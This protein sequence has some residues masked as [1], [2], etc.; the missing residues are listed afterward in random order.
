M[1]PVVT[2]TSTDIDEYCRLLFEYITVKYVHLFKHFGKKESEANN[3]KLPAI[4]PDEKDTK[5]S[6]EIKQ[7]SM[8]EFLDTLTYTDKVAEIPVFL[9]K[10]YNYILVKARKNDPAYTLP[11]NEYKLPSNLLYLEML[12]KTIRKTKSCDA[13]DLIARIIT[14]KNYILF[15]KTPP[16]YLC[17]EENS[18]GMRQKIEEIHPLCKEMYEFVLKL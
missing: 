10:C 13:L 5:Q 18:V 14:H 11:D 4:L 3:F 12:F 7:K 9:Q 15:T 8:E 16:Y 17:E 2:A 1:E 6:S